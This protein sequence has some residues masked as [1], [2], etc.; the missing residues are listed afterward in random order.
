MGLAASSARHLTH[1]TRLTRPDRLW[2]KVVAVSQRHDTSA[3]GV[4]SGR[5]EVLYDPRYLCGG[6]QQ[7]RWVRNDMAVLLV[8]LFVL[9]GP[10][11]RG[12]AE[13]FTPW[14]PVVPC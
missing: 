6:E 7:V 3:A 2:S 10:R 1:L 13:R 4:A 8:A 14:L 11:R 5:I 12:A 9:S